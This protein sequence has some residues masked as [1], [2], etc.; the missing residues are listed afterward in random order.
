[1]NVDWSAEQIR[2]QSLPQ[3]E[4]FLYLSILFTSN[5]RTKQEINKPSGAS[6]LVLLWRNSWGQNVKLYISAIKCGSWWKKQDPHWRVTELSL[7]DGPMTSVIWGWTWSRIAAPPW[8]KG[9]SQRG[10]C[11]WSGYLGA[12]FI[13]KLIGPILLGTEPGTQ[14]RNMLWGR[15]MS[16]FPS[17]TH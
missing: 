7:S 3:E 14:T 12:M 10:L 4:E 1:M 16:G 17:W 8:Q 5:G 2:D 15:V 13:W 9:V 11:I 6:T